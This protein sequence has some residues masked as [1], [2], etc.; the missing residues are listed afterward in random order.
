MIS[1][2]TVKEDHSLRKLDADPHLSTSHQFM[3]LLSFLLQ[4]ALLYYHARNLPG[5]VGQSQCVIKLAFS[6]TR[7][8]TAIEIGF[9]KM[10]LS[11]SCTL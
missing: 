2:H 8:Q 5:I 4:P 9:E 6:M 1:E 3:S 7:A 11:S 10:S